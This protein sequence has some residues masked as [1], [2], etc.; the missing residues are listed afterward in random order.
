MSYCSITSPEPKLHYFSETLSLR[1]GPNRQF[2]TSAIEVNGLTNPITHLELLHN[3]NE[4]T[5]LLESRL[6]AVQ[7]DGVLRCFSED[8]QIEEWKGK[9]IT[10]SQANNE[11]R[12]VR[13]EFALVISIGEA[14]KSLLKNREDVLAVLGNRA[15]TPD[16]CLLLLVTRYLHP[17]SSDEGNHLR[18]QIIHITATED[19]KRPFQELSSLRLPEPSPSKGEKYSYSWQGLNGSLLQNTTTTL[20]IYKIGGLVPQLVH[21]WKLSNSR[22]GSCLQLSPSAAIIGTTTSI[23]VV[24]I[25]FRSLQIECVLETLFKHRSKSDE[26]KY[27]RSNKQDL[28]LLS[29]Y[30]PLNTVIALRGC[31]LIAL[32]LPTWKE[33][34]I[35]SRKRGNDGLLVNSIGRGYALKDGKPSESIFTQN[36]SKSLGTCLPISQPIVGWKKQKVFLDGLIAGDK[37]LDEVERIMM[38]ELDVTEEEISSNRG[39]GLDSTVRAGEKHIPDLRKLNYF[40]SKIFTIEKYQKSAAS[41]QNN[42]IGKLKIAWFPDK[43]CRWLI[44]RGFF[45]K[46]Q[47]E[48]SLKH[49]GALPASNFIATGAF[50]QAVAEWDSSLELLQFILENPVPLN[51]HETVHVLHYMLKH[52]KSAERYEGEKLLTDGPGPDT[53]EYDQA[54]RLPETALLENPMPHLQASD[55]NILQR[56]LQGVIDRL[57]AQSKSTVSR[58]LKDEL[59]LSELRSLVDLLRVRLAQFRWLSHKAENTLQPSSNGVSSESQEIAVTNFFICVIDSIGTSGWVLGAS[60]S[61]DLTDTADT[62]AYMKAEVSAALHG[63]EEATYLESVLGE[64]LLFGK[65]AH[66]QGH[67]QL[68][69]NPAVVKM[70]FPASSTLGIGNALPLGLKLGQNISTKKV[71]VGGEI[72]ERSK[73]DIGRLKSRIVGKYSFDRIVI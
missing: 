51:P 62:I 2:H 63:A 18:F 61:E 16:T 56:L 66:F 33:Q 10:G 26:H 55:S 73:R 3:V 58:A 41:S 71:G 27:K 42:P 59:S 60:M 15:D 38:N 44:R 72:R 29:Y 68:G 9:I 5:A 6:L 50:I 45:S 46:T 11:P 20:T 24:D 31:E 17:T 12:E 14:L 19:S 53:A 7:A 54:L 39:R 21:H 65:N 70:Q 32:Q 25:K 1:S 64:V 49:C 47:V 23:S 22:I 30:T 48:A 37:D 40:L 67:Y 8:L 43:I 13:V 4:E 28:Q 52:M 36:L 34:A 69:S 35:T 57:Q